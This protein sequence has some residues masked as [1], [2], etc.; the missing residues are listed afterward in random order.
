MGLRGE[1][2]HF[3]RPNFLDNVPQT[4]AVRHIARMEEH[5]RP[6]LMRIH[7]KVINPVRIESRAPPENSVHFIPFVE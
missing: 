4:R 2:V 3:I 6:G 5:P 7:V 1:I